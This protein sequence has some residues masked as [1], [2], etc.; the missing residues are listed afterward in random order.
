MNIHVLLTK[1]KN[2]RLWAQCSRGRGCFSCWK[3]T[4]LGQK[5]SHQSADRPQWKQDMLDEFSAWLDEIDE[6]SDQ[7][8]A[9]PVAREPDLETLLREFTALRQEVKLQ[10]R[11]GSKIGDLVTLLS[12][13]LN[14]KFHTIEKLEKTLNEKIPQA[15]RE[16]KRQAIAM[17]F[18]ILEAINRTAESME[19]SSL[20]VLLTPSSRK[21]ALEELMMPLGLLKSKVT[22]LM[23]QIDLQEVA[24]EGKKYNSLQMRAAHTS[25]TGAISNTVT[26]ILRQ[27]YL[28][29]GELVRTAEVIVEK[30]E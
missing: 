16:S 27:G 13:D 3:Q 26:G 11:T 5:K 25:Q 4:L 22:H 10:A 7:S 8:T 15:R 1:I 6:L 23:C 9:T 24:A 14:K 30:H 19:Q 18:D 17:F 28:L 2:S 29:D 21:K 20:P 12:E